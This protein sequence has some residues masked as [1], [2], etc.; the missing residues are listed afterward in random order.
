MVITRRTLDI[1]TVASGTTST[2]RGSRVVRQ[3]VTLLLFTV[4]FTMIYL[5]AGVRQFRRRP[6]CRR[7]PTSCFTS[8]VGPAAEVTYE[9]P[10][11]CTQRSLL[12]LP[13]HQNLQSIFF[14]L[15]EKLYSNHSCTTL[16]LIV[17]WLY[18]FRLIYEGFYPFL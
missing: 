11:N 5:L 7:R 16:S 12:H 18:L 13:L 6:S 9:H 2:T 4:R 15:V 8:V 1:R 17:V 14:V 10:I 3:H